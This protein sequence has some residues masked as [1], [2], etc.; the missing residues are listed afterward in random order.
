MKIKVKIASRTAPAMFKK[1]V[2]EFPQKS[3][4][5]SQSVSFTML[6]ENKGGKSQDNFT[7]STFDNLQQIHFIKAF[8]KLGLEANFFDSTK[9]ILN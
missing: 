8:S 7:I 3:S 2:M 4:L 6:S 1:R 9:S 5:A